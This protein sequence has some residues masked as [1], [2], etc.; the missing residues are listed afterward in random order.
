MIYNTSELTGAL[1]GAA[2]AKAEGM[3]KRSI[4]AN[5]VPKFLARDSSFECNATEDG[6][7]GDE[8]EPSDRWDHGG[9]IIARE[10][11]T[12]RWRDPN[13][14]SDTGYWAAMK[15]ADSPQP[16]AAFWMVGTTALIAAMR[17]FVY[18]KNGAEVDL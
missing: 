17:A 12:I 9:P 16:P 4:R 18:T 15:N 11:I 13:A 1:L 8:F 14:V 3:T 5:V 10:Q 6:E 7:H 2:V